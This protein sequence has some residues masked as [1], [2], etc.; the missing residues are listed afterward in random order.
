M[1]QENGI[2]VE[3]L[4]FDTMIAAHVSGGRNWGLK[5]LALERFGHEMTPI[6]ELIGSGKNQITMAEVSIEEAGKYAS[7]DADYTER[8]HE[9]LK[10]DLEKKDIVDLFLNV[11]IPL[12]PVLV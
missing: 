7:A 9:I 4:E 1:L 8:L 5:D 2:Y 3:G 12:I 10:S 11:E 6:T